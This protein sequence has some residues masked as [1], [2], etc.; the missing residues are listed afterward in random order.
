MSIL[1]QPLMGYPP[2]E[3][4]TDYWTLGCGDVIGGPDPATAPGSYVPSCPVHG[5]Q[6]T[7]GVKPLTTDGT[8]VVRSC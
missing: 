5:S 1:G 2:G 4:D 3:S 7:V 6:G 8:S